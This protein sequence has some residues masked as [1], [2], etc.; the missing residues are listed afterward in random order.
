MSIQ[1]DV[2]RLY[3]DLSKI[4]E[5]RMVAQL[6]VGPTEE[7]RV[8][9]PSG[10]EAVHH[11]PDGYMIIETGPLTIFVDQ[12]VLLFKNTVWQ[13]DEDGIQA[14]YSDLMYTV[15]VKIPQLLWVEWDE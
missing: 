1:D 6:G 5:R 3:Y 11:D 12:S 7:Y 8:V 9:N 10:F 15:S 2:N 4:T 13:V 14:D